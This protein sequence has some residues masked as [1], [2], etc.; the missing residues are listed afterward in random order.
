M[1]AKVDFFYEFASTYSY[2]AAMRIDRVAEAAGV[3]VNWRPFLLG[4]IF[5]AAGMTTSPFNTQ[6]AKG[7]YMWRD[8]E[9]ICQ[10]DRLALKRP[11]PFPQNS[12]LAA[13]IAQA[14]P[15]DGKRAAFSRAVYVAEFG[16]GADIAVPE[17]LG[18]ILEKLGIPAAPLIV[19]AGSDSVKQALRA[20]VDEAKAH[21]MFGAP[22]VVTSDG[23]LFW[24]NDRLDAAIA[25]AA[26]IG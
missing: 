17:T 24:G 7:R 16:E 14:L 9:R 13:R 12:L 25:W 6:P 5:A 2:P 26:R 11:D 1:T 15:D 19:Q 8:L 4:P 20:A 23:E 10:A 22:N 21:G 18:R 3:T